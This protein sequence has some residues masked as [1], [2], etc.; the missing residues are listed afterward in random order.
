M[1]FPRRSTQHS[2]APSL[3]QPRASAAGITRPEV[4][5]LLAMVLL[6]VSLVFPGVVA[7]ERHRQVAAARADIDRLLEAGARFFREYGVWP[8]PDNLPKGDIRYGRERP[9]RELINALR[10]VPGPGNEAS[11]VNPQSIVFLHAQARADGGSGLTASGDYVDPWGR[12]YQVVVDADFDNACD[13]HQSIYGRV[14]GKGMVVWSSGPDRASDT[15]DD[16]LSW[17]TR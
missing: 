3:H 15:A 12:S 16:I 4:V 14:T 5:F 13:I 8:A 9:N 10:A 17:K 6:V 11:T 1:L 2:I 7:L